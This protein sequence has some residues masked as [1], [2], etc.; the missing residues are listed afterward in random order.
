MK[1]TS[2]LLFLFELVALLS[3]AALFIFPLASFPATFSKSVHALHLA[4]EHKII[5][6]S[7]FSTYVWV[8]AAIP[9]LMSLTLS[10]VKHWWN[11]FFLI[12]TTFSILLV[13]YPQ[14]YAFGT[15]AKPNNFDTRPSW[16]VYMAV[17]VPIGTALFLHLHEL[18][19]APTT[20][21]PSINRDKK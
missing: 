8:T 1:L 5:S 7:E 17:Y 14:S 15:D 16:S 21:K 19:S 9:P 18:F 12:L 4:S 6:Y 20:S 10:T 3:Y 11:V 13:V 2:N